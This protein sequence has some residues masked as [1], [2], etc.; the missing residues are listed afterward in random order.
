MGQRR[1]D[2]DRARGP[3]LPVS[4]ASRRACFPPTFPLALLAFVNRPPPPDK[5]FLLHALGK[6]S[7]A[8]P[9]VLREAVAAALLCTH[10]HPE[11]VDAATVQ[12]AAV[13]LLAKSGAGPGG[14]LA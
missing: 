4:F 3:G 12:A 10:V 7:N 9:E 6:H 13:G 5:P 11:A 8:P 1:S 2:E 14:G